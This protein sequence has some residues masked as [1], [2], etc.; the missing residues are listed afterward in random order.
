MNRKVA[1]IACVA[2]LAA[3]SAWAA[4]KA[5]TSAPATAKKVTLNVWEHTPQFEASIKGVIEAFMAKNPDVVV[6]YEIKTPD[7]YYALLSTAIQAGEAPDIFW[8]NGSATTDLANL[9]KQNAVMD[10]SGKI[11]DS[12][13]SSLA[14]KLTVLDGKTWLTP[15]ATVGTR[16]VYYDKDL[17][18]KH[19]LSV[20]KTFAEFEKLLET[21]KSKGVLPISFGGRFTWSI[22]FHF[23][24]ILAAMSPDWLAD[25]S[26]GKA[27]VN[28]P[29]VAAA[30]DKMVEWGNKGYYGPGYLGVDEGGQLLAFS[31]G[32]AAMTLTGSWNA[33]T[34]RKNN[35]NMKVGAFQIPTK[36]GKRP[37]IVT[38]STGY[39]V[40]SKTKNPEAA[41]RLARF[42]ATV[43]AQQIWVDGVKDIPGLTGVTS[44]DPL[45][46]EIIASDFQVPS[47]YSILGDNAKPGATPPTQIW[48]QDN[49]KQLSGALTTAQFLQSLD[50]SM[51]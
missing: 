4:G 44:A 19:G 46:T 16:A 32:D 1:L 17:F 6:E 20:P 22:L 43:E 50:S 49:V 7:Q 8:T 27:R 41:L 11:D 21:L 25:A 18:A 31:K 51:R 23:E 45:I 36:D 42:M 40:Y 38:S 14:R 28:D 15:G 5:E 3:G 47:F 29:R 48:E 39:S 26:E 9:V 37:M 12:A 35:P 13:Y 10:L 2:A 30:F 34:L 24:P 33:D